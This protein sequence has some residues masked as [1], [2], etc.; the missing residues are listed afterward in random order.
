MRPV[1]LLPPSKAHSHKSSVKGLPSTFITL[2]ERNKQPLRALKSV[3]SWTRL[4]G[5]LERTH[6]DTHTRT[7]GRTSALIDQMKALSMKVSEALDS[8]QGFWL[9]CQYLSSCCAGTLRDE[10]A[11]LCWHDGWTDSTGSPGKY[12]SGFIVH[13]S[14]LFTFQLGLIHVEMELLYHRQP[15][16]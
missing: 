10:R 8:L 1:S 4:I 14:V 16:D 9:T 13:S 6:T 7:D 15:L 3:P 2:T 11:A 5:L 12:H